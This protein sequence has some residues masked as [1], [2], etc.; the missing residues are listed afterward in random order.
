MAATGYRNVQ[1]ASD[2]LLAHVNDTTLDNPQP[3]EYVL[4]LCPDGLLHR[5]LQEFW[6]ESAREC[7][8]NGAHEF[9]PH[10]T[11]IPPFQVKHTLTFYCSER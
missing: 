11:L 1:L 7:G 8:R 9:L 3:R 4:Y 10:V 2:W 6:V 5:K